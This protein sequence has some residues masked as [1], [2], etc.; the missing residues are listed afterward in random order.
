MCVCVG[1][2]GGAACVFG[3]GCLGEGELGGDGGRGGAL[4]GVSLC[5]DTRGGVVQGAGFQVAQRI[6]Q[7]CLLMAW[8]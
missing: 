3:R 6:Y 4:G 2:G 5:V 7:H 1:W 8:W